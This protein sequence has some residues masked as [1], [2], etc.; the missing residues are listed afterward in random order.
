MS[1]TIGNS[2]HN[3]HHQYEAL[4]TSL[5]SQDEGQ[6]TRGRRGP[7]NNDKASSAIRRRTTSQGMESHNYEPDESEI[8]R[9]AMAL[10]HYNTNHRTTSSKIISRAFQRWLLTFGIGV[11]Q[12][13]F[14]LSCNLTSK[15]L[16]HRKF[17]AIQKVLTQS[18]NIY[19]HHVTTIVNDDDAMLLMNDDAMGHSSTND[20]SRDNAGLHLLH[21]FFLY[22]GYQVLFAAIAFLFVWIEPVAAGSG[23]PEIKCFLNGVK[24]PRLL[25]WK[26]LACKLCGLAFSVAS[27]MPLGMEGPMVHSGSIVSALI[28]QGQCCIVRGTRT[29]QEMFGQFRNDREKRDFVACGTAAGVCSAF[30]T[31]IGGVLFSLEEASSYYSNDLTW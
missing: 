25:E 3:S 20:T 24:I 19:K 5:Q 14:A 2:S 6:R 18:T 16:S 12:A 4:S 30:G 10:E 26:T 7:Q 1:S 15:Y 11:V 31:P 17:S 8:W 22:T 13:V 27:G 29:R 28:S 9:A 21:A 23:I